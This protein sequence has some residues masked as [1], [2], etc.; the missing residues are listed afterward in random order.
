MKVST[1]LAAGSGLV[2]VLLTAVLAY[3]VV[4]VN[5][6]ARLSGELAKSGL[7]AAELALEQI[8]DLGEMEAALRKFAVT[9]DP[10]YATRARQIADAVD[11][12]QGALA[13]LDLA[14]E[15]RT[16]CG[17][18]EN[19]WRSVRGDLPGG[20]LEESSFEHLLGRLRR[21]QDKALAVSAAARRS[22]SEEASRAEASAREARRIS[23]AAAL[24]A[25]LVGG[26]ALVLTV[27]SIQVPLSRLARG[28]RAVA[29]GHFDQRVESA[30]GDEF[31]SLAA[32]FNEMVRR[33]GELDQMK[34]DLLSH[35]SHELKAPLA[36]MEETNQLLVEG[37]PGPITEDQHRLLDLNLQSVR[38]LSALIA[39]LLDLSRME[40]GVMEYDMRA[41]DLA[42]VLEGPAAEM[43][44]LAREKGVR[45]ALDL[46]A[47]PFMV[48]GDG[49]RL[50]QVVANLL[51][52]AIKFSP[53]GQEVLVS[54][55]RFDASPQALP[56][57]VRGRLPWDTS[58][59]GAVLVTV[60]DRGPGIPED[61]REAIFER[62]HQ[63][64][65]G[66]RRAGGGVGLGLTICREIAHAHR[67]ALWVTDREGGG[68]LFTFALPEL[69][70]EE[71]PAQPGGLE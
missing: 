54:A 8:A 66:R 49:D 52:N 29:Q 18:F 65:R 58:A 14:P 21:A 27:R 28:T 63:V 67:G 2:F 30:G 5:R 34:K 69:R 12:R 48:R 23:Y 55:R 61:Q 35:V 13:E 15:V 26:A 39:K 47:Q 4:Q 32:D 68:S 57:E 51:E 16:E 22:V 17:E 31:A 59:Q 42:P 38:R 24:V 60:A 25:L 19:L 56:E 64:P 37:I 71:V 40:A 53:P 11:A 33:L 36:A 50:Y 10:D 44:V 20:A 46:P 3:E 70:Q 7:A 43:E 45:I 41:R 1:R 6:L 62:F 9:G